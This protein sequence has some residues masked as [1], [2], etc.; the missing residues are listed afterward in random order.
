M[1]DRGQVS[2]PLDFAKN[3]TTNVPGFHIRQHPQSGNYCP[4]TRS[5]K[6]DNL[7]LRP[8]GPEAIR[9]KRGVRNRSSRPHPN[10]VKIQ[11]SGCN[12]VGSLEG[13]QGVP[14][15]W[16]WIGVDDADVFFAEF[17][18]K[19]A[20]GHLRAAGWTHSQRFAIL[21]GAAPIRPRRVL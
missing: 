1:T 8:K 12:S 16:L 9:E 15:V 19:G 7:N 13:E 20:A 18:A 21:G 5:I 3:S 4:L 6:R 2:G 10:P 17:S 14:G 11:A